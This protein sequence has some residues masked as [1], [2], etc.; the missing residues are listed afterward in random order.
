MSGSCIDPDGNI[1]ERARCRVALVVVYLM[2]RKNAPGSIEDCEA[3]AGD[4]VQGMELHYLSK[5]VQA[6]DAVLEQEIIQAASRV[7]DTMGA[8]EMVHIFAR[9]GNIGAVPLDR[10]SDIVGKIVAKLN[11]DSDIEAGIWIWP[12]LE[13]TERVAREHLAVSPPADLDGIEK[14]ILR[15]VGAK[16]Y[17]AALA[18]GD[19][20][21]QPDKRTTEA[22]ADTRQFSAVHWQAGNA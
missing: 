10:L 6:P 3:I 2:G 5:I 13:K 9:A 16:D 11:A 4:I 7:L 15:V 14:S 21:P 22:F 19:L 20:G 18:L 1:H 8:V 17:A 12:T